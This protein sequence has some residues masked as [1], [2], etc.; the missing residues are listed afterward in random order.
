MSELR[1]DTAVYPAWNATMR[2]SMEAETRA[3]ARRV[4][5]AGDGR[6]ETLLLTPLGLVNEALAKVYGLAERLR[7]P[8]LVERQLDPVQRPGVLTRGAFLA[9]HG[10]EGGSHPIRRG[11]V[12]WE[13]LV[14]GEIPP[15]P[16][17]VPTPRPTSPNL[18]T[19]ERFAEHSK[20][21]CAAG[22]HGLLDPAGFA[23]ETYDG[24]GAWR[25]TDGGKPV[26]ASGTLPLPLAGPQGFTGARQMLERLAASEDARRCLVLQWARFALARREV[27][28]E[29][30]SLGAA[31]EAFAR[32]GFDLRALLAALARTRTFLYRAP[33]AGEVL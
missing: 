4:V 23:F 30:A 27:P 19:R 16:M 28:A 7:G 33:A 21:E 2:T 10:A 20:N 11:L 1:K 15:P 29:A 8:D 5:L 6:L 12:V 25:A 22:C 32:A 31:Y 14:C 18:S 26:D 24:I 17:N 3:L 9:V 13:R